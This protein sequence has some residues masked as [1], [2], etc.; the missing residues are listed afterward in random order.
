LAQENQRLRNALGYA[1][2]TPGAWVPAAVISR[3]GGAAAARNTIRVDK[4]S[5]AGVR[6]GAVVTVPEGEESKGFAMLEMLC[7]TLLEKGFT[8]CFYW[9]NFPPQKTKNAP[10]T[11]GF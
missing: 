11:V 10:F 2:K 8:R 3:E 5:L 4:G 6:E 9:V 7:R 1:A